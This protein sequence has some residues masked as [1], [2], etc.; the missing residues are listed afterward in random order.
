MRQRYE[1]DIDGSGRGHTGT[2]A[3]I[4]DRVRD[5]VGDVQQKHDTRE[6]VCAMIISATRMQ[7]GT[8]P[9]GVRVLRSG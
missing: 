7:G 2:D 3:A 6:S 4:R 1:L 5:L 9:R 8:P